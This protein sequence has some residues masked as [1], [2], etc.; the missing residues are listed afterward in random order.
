MRW[1][2][3]RAFDTRHATMGATV[4]ATV[5]WERLSQAQSQGAVA[6]RCLQRSHRALSQGT[7][8]GHNHGA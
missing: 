2:A 1:L 8:T 6:G 5:T 3:S 7:A 4:G